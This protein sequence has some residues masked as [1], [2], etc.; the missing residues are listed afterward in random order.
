MVGALAAICQISPAADSP[1]QLEP[2]HLSGDGSRFVIG[3]SDRPFRPWGVN[4]DH[5]STAENGRLLEDYWI[6][7]WPTVESDFA[8]IA[9]LGAN[10]V[11]I[12]LQVAKFM[13]SPTETNAASLAQLG[14]LLDLADRNHLYLD[15]T[16]L[17]CYHKQDVPPWYDALDEAGRWAVQAR[18]WSAIARQCKDHPAVFCFDL[19]NEPII[20]GTEKDGW[21][22]GE[23]G[24][25]HFVQRLTLTPGDR[26]PQ[27]IAK[28]WVEKLTVAIR[29][30]DP[31]RLITVGVIPWALTWP[32]AKPV[33]YSP[34]VSSLLDFVCV[35]FYPKSGEIDKALTALSVYDIGK[36]MVIE[37]TFPLGC[38]QEELIDFLKRSRD[39]AEGVVSFYWGKT[40]AELEADTEHPL[41]AGMVA[42]WLKAFRDLAPDMK[43]P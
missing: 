17:G 29:Q 9:A 36:P 28:T 2:I 6:D 10:V 34:E 30:E 1:S 43:A 8:E 12:H 21:L 33:F 24:G 3:D 14:R 38:S 4:Y 22:A 35:H 11:R 37:E 7:E 39:I 19:M 13:L 16:G 31:D 27:A 42:A 26:S 20:S 15:L 25:K 40:I 23:L 32:K 5:D 41:Q 18:F